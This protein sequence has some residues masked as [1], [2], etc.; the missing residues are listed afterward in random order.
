MPLSTFFSFV[1]PGDDVLQV[2]LR[3]EVFADE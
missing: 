1:V 3:M 2:P